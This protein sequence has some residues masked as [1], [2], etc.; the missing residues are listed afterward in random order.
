MQ[1]EPRVAK[2][3]NR[4]LD[5][6][7]QLDELFIDITTNGSRAWAPNSTIIPEIFYEDKLL[8]M[9]VRRVLKMKQKIWNY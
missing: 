2:F 6:C 1:V 4:G 3:T 5:N 7:F 8:K 9:M